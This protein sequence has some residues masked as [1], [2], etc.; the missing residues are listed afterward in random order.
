MT[1]R[2]FEILKAAGQFLSESDVSGFSVKEL[3]LRM[4]TSEEAI[5]RH[6][7]SKEEIIVALLDYMANNM[8]SRFTEAILPDQRPEEKFIALFQSQFSFSEKHPHLVMAMFSKDLMETSRRLNQNVL[9]L[10]AVI[11]KHL[12]PI[13]K[14]GQRIK[15]FTTAV[16][17]KNLTHIILRT[18]HL[19]MEKWQATDFKFDIKYYGNNMIESILNLI[20]VEPD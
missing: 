7:D 1:D 13:I 9:R 11:M 12:E 20:E 3:A 4:G 19:Q 18:F 2:Q 6:F 10:I 14:E 8:D 15:V 17:T 16:D 5:H